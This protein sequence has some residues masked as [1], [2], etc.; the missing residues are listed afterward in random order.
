[1]TAIDYAVLWHS[2]IVLC[3][4]LTY[5]VRSFEEPMPCHIAANVSA[6]SSR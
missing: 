1:M 2:L 5:W 4:H 3:H 6:T